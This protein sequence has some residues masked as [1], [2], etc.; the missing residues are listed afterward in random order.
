MPICSTARAS[1]GCATAAACCT[2]CRPGFNATREP[3]QIGAELYGHAGLEADHRGDSPAGRRARICATSPHRAS[4]SAMSRVFR[5]LD[6][7]G[8]TGRRKPKRNC[9]APCRARMCRRVRE[10]LRGVADPVRAALLALPE[11]Y[12]DR[13]VLDA[14]GAGLAGV[15]RDRCGACPTCGASPTRW[16]TCRLSFDLADLRGYHYHSG[17]VFAAYCAGSSGAVALGGRYDDFGRAFGR[18]PAGHRFFAWTCANWR[19]CRR[20]ASRAVRFSLRGPK[21]MPA[22][23]GFAEAVNAERRCARRASV[24][25]SPCRDTRARGAKPAATG[26]WCAAAI[27]GSLNP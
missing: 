20:T 15:A 19:A 17:V 26:S 12:G 6:Q 22:A 1:R 24:W 3:L 14:C 5:A 13:R 23:D 7:A 11:L 2:P 16:P 25:C 8:R 9:S 10:L 18:G 4:T 27:T 21:T